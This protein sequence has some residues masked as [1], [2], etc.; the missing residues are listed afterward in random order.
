MA[1]LKV[2]GFKLYDNQIVDGKLCIVMKMRL[3]YFVYLRIKVFFQVLLFKM[4]IGNPENKII[5]KYN[6]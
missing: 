1:K 3:W 5:I 6:V 4:R 2:F